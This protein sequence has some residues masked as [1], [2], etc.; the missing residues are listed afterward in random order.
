MR[1]RAQ[2]RL[3]TMA[4]SVPTDDTSR[5]L[6]LNTLLM[7]TAREIETAHRS[8][9]RSTGYRIKLAFERLEAAR[10][11]DSAPA[12][13]P[14]PDLRPSAPRGQAAL[15]RLDPFED[16]V[17]WER[18]VHEAVRNHEGWGFSMLQG[19]GAPLPPLPL[20][21]PLTTLP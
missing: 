21:S 11:A 8:A 14:L 12:P 7:H 5:H 15:N 10:P 2:R 6:L 4:P 16:L 17:A 18:L 1:E 19:S 13:A 9:S 3:T 20:P